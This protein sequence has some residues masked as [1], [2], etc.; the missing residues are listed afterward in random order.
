VT[1]SITVPIRVR[2]T[3]GPLKF[4]KGYLRNVRNQAVLRV[5]DP[6]S[7][8]LNAKTAQIAKDRKSRNPHVFRYQRA[9]VQ[10][11]SVFVQK[12]QCD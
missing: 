4:P 12:R 5:F 6:L 7:R 10:N 2:F 9:R 11:G 8:G 3:S 1:W